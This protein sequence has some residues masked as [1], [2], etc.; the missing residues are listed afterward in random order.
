MR[1]RITI[2][3]RSLLTALHLI[4][5]LNQRAAARLLRVGY[6]IERSHDEDD[7]KDATGDQ[8]QVDEG[9]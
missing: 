5:Y 3:I 4:Q 6:S 1:T 8:E 2:P 9:K 7:R